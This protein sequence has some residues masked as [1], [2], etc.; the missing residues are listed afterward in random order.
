MTPFSLSTFFLNACIKCKENGGY[1]G[2]FS[3]FSYIPP[4]FLKYMLCIDSCLCTSKILH[5]LSNSI[6]HPSPGTSPPPLCLPP[7]VHSLAAILSHTDLPTYSPP[8]CL[9]PRVQALAAILSHTDLTTD[10][11]PPPSVS[12]HVCR[13]WRPSFPTL[14]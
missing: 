6:I 9:P 14:T 5:Q 7:R 2:G 13:Q 1:F 12:H 11:S 3:F 10:P 4:D 8:L